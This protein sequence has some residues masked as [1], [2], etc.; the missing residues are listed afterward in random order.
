MGPGA[1]F[2][3]I[4]SLLATGKPVL[5]QVGVGPGDDAALLDPGEGGTVVISCDLSIEEVHF[6]RSWLSSSEIGYR[7]AAAALSD[8]AAMAAEPIGIL[9]SVALPAERAKEEVPEIQ[10]G[11]EELLATIGGAV[12]GGDL[13]TSPGPLVLDI[14]AVG[15]ST[16][17]ALRSG[18]EEG[19]ELW[20]T[21]SLGGSAGAVHAWREGEPPPLLREIYARP[22]PRL[23]EARWL[24]G[25]TELH[26]LIDLSDGLAGDAGHLAAASGVCIVVREDRIPVNPHLRSAGL[27]E[28]DALH[29]A[30]CGGEDYELLLVA[31]T[32]TVD[33]LTDAFG[34]R[35]GVAL[36]HIGRVEAGVGAY[37]ARTGGGEPE[38]MPRCGFDHLGERR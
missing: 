9:V 35:F 26:A 28:A 18:A 10:R 14:V 8:L 25:R 30:L 22:R 17:P 1:E 20:V 31:K 32:G 36:T 7:A 38:P 33:P 37:I 11:M 5:P 4:R 23:R 15:R 24:A 12:L 34:D 29:L 19:D 27:E 13:S 6:R 16:A 3:L 21:G 2:D